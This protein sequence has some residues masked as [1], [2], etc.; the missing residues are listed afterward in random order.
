M[1]DLL[2]AAHLLPQ[3]GGFKAFNPPGFVDAV[4]PG[5][6]GFGDGESQDIDLLEDRAKQGEQ[7][8]LMDGLDVYIVDVNLP[9]GGLIQPQQQL[10]QRGLAR[11]V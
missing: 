5:G 9:A 2:K 4:L 6:Y 7:V 8:V 1:D 11:A 10:D 3:A